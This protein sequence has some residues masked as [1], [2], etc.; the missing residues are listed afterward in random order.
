MESV[1]NILDD[2]VIGT[3]STLNEDG[4][5]WSTPLHVVADDEALYWFSSIRTQ[6]SRNVERD[7]RV[8]LS[9][10]SP[11]KSKGLKALYVSGRVEEVA[12]EDVKAVRDM[13]EKRIG[14]FPEAFESAAA[15]KLPIGQ[16]NE[17]KSFGNCWYFYTQ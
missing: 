17:D 2:N 14:A 8:S 9:V 10:F 15:Y 16:L 6:H 3:L 4:S 12:D 1:R 7:P 11:D 5:P 13:L